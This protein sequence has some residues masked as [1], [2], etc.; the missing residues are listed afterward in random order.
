MVM[1]V[2]LFSF[3]LLLPVGV[4]AAGDTFIPAPA[5]STQLKESEWLKPEAISDDMSWVR[6]APIIEPDQEEINQTAQEEGAAMG[7]VL[8]ERASTEA[9]PGVPQ[10]NAAANRPSPDTIFVFISMGMTDA[11]LKDLFKSGAGRD[12]VVYLLRGWNPPN[13]YG[14]FAKVRELFTGEPEPNISIQ[15]YFFKHL[16]IEEVPAFVM[17]NKAGKVRQINGEISLS[18]AEKILKSDEKLPLYPVGQLSQIEEPN[19][20]DELKSRINE[21]DWS[22][23]MASARERA[24]QKGYGVDLP[25]AS[26]D[27][28][29]RVDI[30]AQINDDIKLPDG[31]IVAQKG[32]VIN[33]LHHI[34]MRYRYVFFDPRDGR[35]VDQVKQWQDEFSNLKLIATY[36]QPLS[37]DSEAL[38]KELGQ[39]IFPANSLLV[40]RFS[41]LAIPAIVEQ[42]GA[43]L[44]ISQIKPKLSKKI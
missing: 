30:S 29:Y 16:R 9:L 8:R 14:L 20:L 44:K 2:R 17:V 31:R 12:D 38:I 26:Q 28:I 24:R 1:F 42:D 10:K 18:G 21:F 35:Q 13:L 43:L 3:L 34:A 32:M 36:Y 15:P 25:V 6:H 33:P 7:E 27:K 37:E 4:L 39:P 41:V 23:Q 19:I 11:S 40:E 5:G 22:G